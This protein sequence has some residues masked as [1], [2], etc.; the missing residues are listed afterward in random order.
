MNYFTS[1]ILIIAGLAFLVGM[2]MRPKNVERRV[3]IMLAAMGLC[4]LVA[5]A[6][7]LW[8]ERLSKEGASQNRNL[9]RLLIVKTFAGGLGGG[10]FVTVLV[11]EKRK[12]G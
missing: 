11:L 12:G 6:S 10:I 3:A 9:I 7:G 2:S 1:A 8:S 5:G 4:F